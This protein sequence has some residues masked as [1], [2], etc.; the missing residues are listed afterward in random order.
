MD[1]NNE[2][3][4]RECLG[5]ARAAKQR[6]D[7]PV[8]AILVRNGEIIARGIEGGKTHRDITYHAEIEA[9]REAT[10]LLN[11]QNLSDCIMYTTHEP[12]IMCAYVIR[13]TRIPTI[14][15]GLTSGDIGGASSAYPLLKDTGIKKWGTPP[16]LITGVL[17]EAC[18]ALNI[19]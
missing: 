3:F 7:S 4:M 6:G 17:E 19:D 12:C 15:M 18:K 8:G 2:Y 10:A 9:I 11:T 14:V 5:L 16:Q 1:L 13:H